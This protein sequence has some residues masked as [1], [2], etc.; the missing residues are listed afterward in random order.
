VSAIF[1]GSISTLA[2]TSEVQRRAFNEA[3]SAH[4]LD[5]NWSRDEYRSMLS[6][7]GGAD[8]VSDYAKSVGVEV[9][10][11]AVHATK[12]EIFQQLLA[13]SG[14][15]PR[16]GVVD[17]VDYAKAKGIKLGLV[18]TTSQA[19]VDALLSALETHIGT[20]AFDVVVVKDSVDKPKPDGACY[21]W[22][23]DQLELDALKAVAI[24]DNVGGVKAAVAA[25]VPCIAFPNENT[26]GGDFS[27]AAETVDHLDQRQV[28]SF[29]VT[30]RSVR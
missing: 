19:N 24:E 9:D 12:S 27:A 10:A 23:L 11:S 20:D 16:P 7:N 26:A 25:G 28:I 18:T 6:S 21:E 17:T 4:G 22:A 29:A 14:V 13:D 8:R 5:W 30:E 3:F 15:E 1:F 2:D